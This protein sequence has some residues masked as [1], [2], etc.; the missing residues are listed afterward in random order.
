MGAPN[1]QGIA[2]HMQSPI[3]VHNSVGNKS[4]NL[5]QQSAHQQYGRTDPSTQRVRVVGNAQQT[6]QQQPQQRFGGF[7]STLQTKSPAPNTAWSIIDQGNYKSVNQTQLS[8]T[9][10]QNEPK[11]FPPQQ[12]Q[13]ENLQNQFARY[14][15]QSQQQVAVLNL[16]PPQRQFHSNLNNSYGQALVYKSAMVQSA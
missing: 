14:P 12:P 1:Q 8:N 5:K 13:T 4:L 10:K 9:Y 15:T 11:S 3:F 6:I 16:T 2:A 7:S